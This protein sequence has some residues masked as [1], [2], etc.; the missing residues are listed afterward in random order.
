MKYGPFLMKSETK[1][2]TQTF[3]SDLKDLKTVFSDH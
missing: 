3:V 2:L 1:P